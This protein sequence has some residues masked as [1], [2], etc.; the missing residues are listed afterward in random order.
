MSDGAGVLGRYTP[1][2]QPAEPAADVVL[3]NFPLQLFAAARQRHDDLMREFA[4]LGMRPLEDRPGREVPARLRELVDVLSRQHGAAAE[5][6]DA[7]RDAAIARGEL[8]MDLTYRLPRSAVPAIQGLHD[9]MDAAEEFCLSEQ[10]LTPPRTPTQLAFGTW[11]FGQLTS[12][13]QGAEP[14]PWDGPLTDDAA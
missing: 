13:L 3:L 9:L 5:R 14:V 12:Q 2:P 4:L 8:T 6:A 10:L 7:A 1:E 11:F